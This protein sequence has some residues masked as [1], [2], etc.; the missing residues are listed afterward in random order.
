MF[1]SKMLRIYFWLIRVFY[2]MPKYRSRLQLVMYSFVVFVCAKIF[3]KSIPLATAV[4][5]FRVI[6]FV[7]VY[8]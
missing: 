1:F 8:I 7:V 6:A 4:V 2:N 5:I 3:N